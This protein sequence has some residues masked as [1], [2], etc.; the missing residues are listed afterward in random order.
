MMWPAIGISYVVVVVVIDNW[1]RIFGVHLDDGVDDCITTV[2]CVAVRCRVRCN[3]K[4]CH[5]CRPSSFVVVPEQMNENEETKSP[6][7]PLAQYRTVQWWADGDGE[8]ERTSLVLDTQS[9][10]LSFFS[11]LLC[12]AL[13][14]DY[15]SLFLETK[16]REKKRTDA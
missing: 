4:L 8:R 13:L 5:R 15:I 14:T 12:C 11:A 1:R 9:Y 16:R 7:A 3:S 2:W 10:L 6:L